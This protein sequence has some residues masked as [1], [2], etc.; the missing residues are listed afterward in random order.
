MALL[1]MEGFEGVGATT[2]DANAELALKY[3]TANLNVVGG[4]VDSGRISGSSFHNLN[5]PPTPSITTPSFGNIGTIV[6]GWGWKRPTV[7][8]AHKIVELLE[9]SNVAVNVRLKS[10]GEFEIYNGN[11][12]LYTTSG[13]DI[14]NSTWAYFELKVTTA[15]SGTYELK[16]NGSSVTGGPQSGDTQPGS[17]A[18][19]NTVR[20]DWPNNYTTI[21]TD[22]TN[23]DDIYILDSSGSE[24]NTFLG[25][26]RV[27][28]MYPNAAGDSTQFTPSTGNNYAAVDENPSN[29]DT[30]YVEDS[31]SGNKDL[32]NYD[33]V[34]SL[35][36]LFGVQINTT[37]K[38]SGFSLKQDVKS[39]GTTSADSGTALG[40]GYAYIT[41]IVEDDP[42]TGSP[43]NPTALNAAQ[44]GVEVV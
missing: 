43:W 24:N 35:T 32:Y 33:S 40:A 30:D 41:R 38:G 11:T 36:R 6:V 34:P 23:F 10:T 26:S 3:T 25:D 39:V 18:Y 13:A 9:G 42:A 19:V 29:G 7:Y 44:F 8:V 1:W 31:T 27:V 16:I 14:G 37:A 4:N 20:F 17:N 12:L 28:A 21:T 5:F 15:N 2:N 22:F